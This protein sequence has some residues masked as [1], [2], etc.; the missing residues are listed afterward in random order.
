M[1]KQHADRVIKD[2]IKPLYGFALNKTAKFFSSF[3]EPKY[4]NW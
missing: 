2:Y 1:N 4:E 3:Y